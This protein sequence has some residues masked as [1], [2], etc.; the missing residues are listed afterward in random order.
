VDGG[1]SSLLVL[2]DQL[3]ILGRTM[4]QVLDAVNASDAVALVAHGRFLAEKF[5]PASQGG[6]LGLDGRLVPPEQT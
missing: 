6:S 2:I 4:D 5:G 1:R 3:D